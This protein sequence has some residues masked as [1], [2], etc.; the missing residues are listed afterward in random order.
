MTW[1]VNK[2]VRMCEDK[3]HI[4]HSILVTS[5]CV[6]AIET[7][8]YIEKYVNE[9]LDRK[10]HSRVLILS[11]CHGSEA[12]DDG[13]NSLECLS[14]IDG[15]GNSQTRAFYEHWAGFFK[16]DLWEDPRDY[17]PTTGEVIGIKETVM[18][19]EWA[20]SV[21][22]RIPGYYEGMKDKMSDVSLQIVDIAFYFGKPD[23]LLQDIKK[24]SPTTVWLD[25]SHS[26]DGY[27]KKLLT[28]SGLVNRNILNNGI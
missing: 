27:T 7:T 20:G 2:F 24:F 15:Y 12:G 19:P 16:Q 28:N 9:L 26:R 5:D 18:R 17:D 6:T 4:E 13:L 14:G 22:G 1:E 21:P 3:F 10:K 8:R 23:E 25:W 11:G